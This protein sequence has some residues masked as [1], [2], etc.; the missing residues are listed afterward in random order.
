MNVIHYNSFGER[1]SFTPDSSGQIEFRLPES[2]EGSVIIGTRMLRLKG[3]SATVYAGELADGVHTPYLAL[4]GTIRRMESIRILGR[5]VE[6]GRTEDYLVRELIERVRALETSLSEN[7][8]KINDLVKDIHG[9]G[10]F[11]T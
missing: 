7:T 5:R 8:K 9:N 4:D 10:L 2:T 1:L 3:G 6:V 11:E